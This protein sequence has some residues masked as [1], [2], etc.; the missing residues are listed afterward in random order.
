M[1]SKIHGLSWLRCWVL[2]LSMAEIPLIYLLLLFQLVWY[3]CGYSPAYSPSTQ[4]DTLPLSDATLPHLLS[5]TQWTCVT[6]HRDAVPPTDRGSLSP[7]VSQA[8]WIVRQQLMAVLPNRRVGLKGK[9]SQS[10]RE[11]MGMAVIQRG[12]KLHNLTLRTKLGCQAV[13]R[14]SRSRVYGGAGLQHGLILFW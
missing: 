11:R 5:T 13:L 2:T 3:L 6:V 10:G 7:H 1:E 14:A 4:P 9:R 12:V 8:Q